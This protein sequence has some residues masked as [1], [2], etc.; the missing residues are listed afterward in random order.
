MASVVVTQLASCLTAH[1]F[2]GDCTQ[3]AIAANGPEVVVFSCSP[4]AEPARWQKLA[5]LR[6]HSQ[7]VC[8][9]DWAPGLG[10]PLLS[11]AHDRN[12]YVWQGGGVPGDAAALRPALVVHH[13]TRAALCAAWA[14]GARKFAVAS[15]CGQVAVCG[16]E[17]GND[18]WVGKL[19]RKGAGPPVLALAW[20]PGGAVLAAGGADGR[21]RLLAGLL[22]G[23]DA[24][25]GDTPR[26]GELL[27]E[28]APAAGAGWV[29]ALA[30]G[31]S[32]ELGAAT[33]GGGLSLWA[34]LDAARSRDWAATPPLPAQSLLPP[35]GALPFMQL[36]FLAPS[37]A[38]AAGFDG[39]PR[40]LRRAGG[41][42][43]WA[44][45]LP[46]EE[47]GGGPAADK[48]SEVRPSQPF[49]PFPLTEA[50]RSSQ[51]ASPASAAPLNAAR[52]RRRLARRPCT[53]TQSHSCACCPPPPPR[54]SLPSPHRR[55][56]GAWRCGRPTKGS[57]RSSRGQRSPE[58]AS[59][60]ARREML[61]RV[62]RSGRDTAP[63][64]PPGIAT[65]PPAH[66]PSA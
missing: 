60:T 52:R 16:Y 42:W 11:A 23:T 32:G 49:S 13:L 25:S 61:D 24:L 34:P 9:L 45:A 41:L 33:H 64:P 53:P 5:T 37:L 50:P 6:E 8:A 56:M 14:P 51:S 2:N 47:A 44:G 3:L 66:P 30:W 15:A 18:W 31:A 36:A 28:L 40:L 39:V 17:A 26:V 43:E 7:V 20:H 1:A 59:L 21:V 46:A 58:S 22:K 4:L 38:V 62:A 63:P 27:A 54:L 35:A 19:A 12:V 57:L 29:H 55:R 48:R 65:R 10:G